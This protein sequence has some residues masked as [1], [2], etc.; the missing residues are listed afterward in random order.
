[1]L[2]N[3]KPQ[4]FGDHTVRLTYMDGDARCVVEAVIGGNNRGAGILDSYTDDDFI[5]AIQQHEGNKKNAVFFPEDAGKAHGDVQSFIFHKPDGS[6][7]I[8]HA[9][10]EEVH[11]Y[12]V[13]IEIIGYTPE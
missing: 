9:E 11:R 4:S 1:M 3:Y 7:I 6:T 10:E 8:K 12:L 2:N 5:N 13:A